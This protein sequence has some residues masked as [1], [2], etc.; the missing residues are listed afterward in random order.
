M[1]FQ[2]QKKSGKCYCRYCTGD[3]NSKA[4]HK[5]TK[6]GARQLEK[7]E[8]KDGLQKVIASGTKKVR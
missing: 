3:N 8:A 4:V 2:G 1:R 6:H 5:A 7:K